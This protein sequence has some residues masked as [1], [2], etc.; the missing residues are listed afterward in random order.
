MEVFMKKVALLL[1]VLF[2]FGCG[3]GGGTTT[4]T[5]TG[6]NPAGG[7][8]TVPLASFTLK[9]VESDSK[10]PAKT[11]VE[12]TSVPSANSI[13][14]IARQFGTA[15]EEI[16]E[17]DAINDSYT[18][19]DP[20]QYQTVQGVEIFKKVTDQVYTTGSTVTVNLPAGTGYTLDVITSNVYAP[21]K[22]MMLKYGSV[23]S[24]DIGGTSGSVSIPIFGFSDL[25]SPLVNF[26]ATPDPITSENNYNLNVTVAK[27]LNPN[28]KIRQDLSNFAFT[29]YS[30]KKLGNISV[31]TS[32]KAPTSF[33]DGSL[34]F[35]GLFTIDNAMLDAGESPLNWTRV[36]PNPN[37]G[38][39]VSCSLLKVVPIVIPG[40]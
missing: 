20:K 4:S 21:G 18:S 8:G 9:L 26:T 29:N 2:M 10:T 36:Y 24:V 15:Q 17:Y 11:V 19:Y 31:P 6:G 28:Y 37:Y 23:T 16:F 32:F 27:L 38:E 30:S 39:S 25:T 12:G 5:N 1:S 7:N 22:H 40:L 13:R 33:D 3:S 14:V 34:Y 35:R